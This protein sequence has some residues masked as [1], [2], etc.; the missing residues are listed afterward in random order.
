MTPLQRVGRNDA[1]ESSDIKA[2]KAQCFY[3]SKEGGRETCTLCPF[4]PF[5]SSLRVEPQLAGEGWILTCWKHFKVLR[6]YWVRWVVCRPQGRLEE[7]RAHIIS[8]FQAWRCCN[9]LYFTGLVSCPVPCKMLSHFSGWDYTPAVKINV[10][11][12][13][14]IS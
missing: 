5:F 14:N 11:R 12:K 8:S 3:L 4:R 10:S 7:P 2:G 13:S 6:E 9:T 1:W